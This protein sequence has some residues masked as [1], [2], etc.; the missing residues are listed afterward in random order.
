MSSEPAGRIVHLD[1]AR[2]VGIILVILGHVLILFATR[3]TAFDPEA[4]AGVRFI[5]A[6]HMPLF[7]FLSGLMHRPRNPASV[8]S[9]SLGLIFLAQLAQIAAGLFDGGWLAPQTMLRPLLGLTGFSIGVTWFLVSLAMVR[10]LVLAWQQGGTRGRIITLLALI[11]SLAAAFGSGVQYLQIHTWWAGFVF[12]MAGHTL[13]GLA[14]D[15]LAAT[16]L[17]GARAAFWW[18]LPATLLALAATALI[19]G[20]NR[21][22]LINPFAT[23]GMEVTYGHFMVRMITGDYGFVPLFLLAAA[24]GIAGVLLLSALMARLPA[25]PRRFLSRIG[26]NTL[27]LLILNGFVL[28]IGNHLLRQQLPEDYPGWIP[29]ALSVIMLAGHAVLLPLA[30]PVVTRAERLCNQAARAVI[31]RL[32]VPARWSADPPSSRQSGHSA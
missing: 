22:C 11:A 1:M 30:I 10:I 15:R 16:S 31:H 3:P 14:R 28:M 12:Y 18:L 9:G 26:E 13:T 2:A 8:L 29:A 19:S 21:G 17:P 27:T 20:W 24:S 7:F 6:F 5:Y 4:F 32:P 25:S 23:C